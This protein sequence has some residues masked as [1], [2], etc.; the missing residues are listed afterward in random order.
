VD[1]KPLSASRIKTLQSCSWLYWA[2]YGMKL[3][4]KTNLGAQLGSIAHIIFE[5]LGNPRHKKIYTKALKNKNIYKVECLRRLV[6]KH[7]YKMNISD[8]QE[9]LKLNSM[10]IAG[11]AYDFFGTKIDKPNK[12]YS[13]LEFDILVEEDGKD[14]RI[15]GFIDKLFLYKQKNTALI[16]D[17]KTS[18]KAFDGKEI[19]DNLQDQMYALAV[20]KLYPDFLKIKVEFPFLQLMPDI[21][22]EAIIKM[23]KHTKSEIEGFEYVLTEIQKII[24][25]FSE[26]DAKLNMA[27]YKS[28]PSDKSFS[29]RLLCGF[30]DYKGHLKKDGAPRWG[31]PYKWGF[32]Y[33]AVRDKDNNILSTYFLD[34]FDKIEYNEEN[35]EIIFLEKYNGCPAW[36]KK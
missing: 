34:D 15:K 28:F 35:G 29:G 25:S 8:K 19:E 30:D 10:V 24:D 27:Y 31:C 2:K 14:Y 3:P 22:N 23:E 36:N 9:A 26:K 1:K 20:Q 6:K 33:Y 13:E 17:F 21:G 16:R 32:E 5:C 18:K 12:S 11:L 7:F 4:E